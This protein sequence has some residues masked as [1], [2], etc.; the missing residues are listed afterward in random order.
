[1]MKIVVYFERFSEVRVKE[2]KHI[3][4]LERDYW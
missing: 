3:G 2:N 1:M 4:I